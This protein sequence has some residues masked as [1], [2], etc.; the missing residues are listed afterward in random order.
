M[1]SGDYEQIIR[2]NVN[3]I[4]IKD[5]NVLE[6]KEVCTCSIKLVI[7]KRIREFK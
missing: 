6:P 3:D 4:C 5:I 7:E 2:L 1:T